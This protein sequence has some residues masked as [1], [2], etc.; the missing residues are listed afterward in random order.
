[1]WIAE[2]CDWH[3]RTRNSTALFFFLK[4]KKKKKIVLSYLREQTIQFPYI[5]IYTYTH[6][7]IS[8]V[9]ACL[10]SVCFIACIYR[11]SE[12]VKKF[13]GEV[14][15]RRKGKDCRCDFTFS[16]KAPVPICML[17]NSHAR[18]QEEKN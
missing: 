3:R 4:K 12:V 13:Q 8:C 15:D 11:F 1:M 16:V 14:G 9:E 18:T 10:S 2:K 6:T 5:Y 7:H 17:F